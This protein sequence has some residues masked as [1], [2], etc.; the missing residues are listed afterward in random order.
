VPPVAALSFLTDF[1]DQAL[2]L[3]LA[4]SIA[5][6]LLL[7]RSWRVAAAWVLA[8][9]AVLGTVAILKTAGYACFWLWPALGSLRSTSGHTAAATVVYGGIAGVAAARSRLGLAWTAS[10]AGLAAGSLIGATRLLLHVHSPAEV[11]LGLVIGMAGALAFAA[12]ARGH[13]VP[14]AWKMLGLAGMVVVLLHGGRLQAEGA[15]QT[16]LATHIQRW[17]SVCRPY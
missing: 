5:A 16:K 15:I 9:T 13:A 6:A 17:V 4:A 1:A 7:S 10:I 2:I 14:A 11:A 3:P 12:L 8:V